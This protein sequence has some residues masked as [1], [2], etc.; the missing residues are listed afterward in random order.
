MSAARQATA[1]FVLDAADAVGFKLGTDG[2]SLNVLYPLR[3]GQDVN[4]TF[5]RALNEYWPEIISIILQ[6]QTA[7][8]RSP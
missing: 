6:E 7:R 5:T 2:T 1:R 8:E 3:L 4:R